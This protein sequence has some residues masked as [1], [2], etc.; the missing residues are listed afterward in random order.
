MTDKAIIKAAAQALCRTISYPEDCWR[1]YADTAKHILTT[2]TPLILEQA[3]QAA[4]NYDIAGHHYPALT[5]RE[6]ATA[7]RALKEQQ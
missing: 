5:R 4:E 2:I 1:M 6:I 3:A 7:I